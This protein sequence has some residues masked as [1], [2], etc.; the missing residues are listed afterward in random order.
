VND[1]RRGLRLGEIYRYPRPEQPERSLVD[2]LPNFY[3]HTETLG[4]PKAKLERGISRLPAVRDEA[5]VSRV[6]AIL[7]R[8]TPWK[9]GTPRTPWHDEFDPARGVVSYF[10]DNKV[11]HVTG[12][13]KEVN[14]ADV[15]GNRGLLEAHWA[16]GADTMLERAAG[17]P[18]LLL[19][20]VTTAARQKGN[21]RFDGLGVVTEARFV[22][23]VDELT[24]EPFANL[25]FEIR[26]LDL[27][28]DGDRVDWAW[29]S[30]RRGDASLLSADEIAPRAWNRWSSE[31]H[32]ALDTVALRTWDVQPL[33]GA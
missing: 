33:S 9:A 5:G 23:Q 20:G 24:G 15:L 19:T 31:G 21:V 4:L 27:S 14:P 32:G 22:R 28:S 29:I 17:P 2:G 6:P 8:S 13:V 16:H 1:D 12:V 3:W 30:A 7:L 18:V 26:L 10:G 25:L 11:D